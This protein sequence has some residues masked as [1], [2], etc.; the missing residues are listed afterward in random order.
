MLENVDM[1]KKSLTN[2]IFNSLVFSIPCKD[3]LSLEENIMIII[4]VL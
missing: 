3:D 1:E 2:Q 4:V